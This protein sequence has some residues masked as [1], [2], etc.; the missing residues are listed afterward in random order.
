MFRLIRIGLV[1]GL[2]AVAIAATTAAPTYAAE[3]QQ[4]QPRFQQFLFKPDVRLVSRPFTETG[5]VTTWNWKI[6]NIGAADSGPI[7]VKATCD[8]DVIAGTKLV[9]SKVIPGLKSGQSTWLSYKCAGG[10]KYWVH[11]DV[12]VATQD[13]LDTSNNFAD[14]DND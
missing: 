14:D 5:T 13:D 12:S 1:F 2:G 10:L 3:G 4:S 7:T 8:G 9:V 11:T 6:E